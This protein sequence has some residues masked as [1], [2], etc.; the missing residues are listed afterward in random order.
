MESDSDGSS[1]T[2]SKTDK[3][4]DKRRFKNLVHQD[5]TSCWLKQTLELLV[6]LILFSRF[7]VPRAGTRERWQ[8]QIEETLSTSWWL[9]VPDCKYYAI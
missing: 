9:I 7:S 2:K 8:Q 6:N 4:Q 5:F 3:R 1:Q